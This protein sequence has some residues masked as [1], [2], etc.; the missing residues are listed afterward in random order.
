MSVNFIQ[1]MNIEYLLDTIK[2]ESFTFEKRLYL[3]K[4]NI[5][6]IFIIPIIIIDNG[7]VKLLY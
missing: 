2:Y 6:R 7:V 5:T 3:G 1:N 4:T